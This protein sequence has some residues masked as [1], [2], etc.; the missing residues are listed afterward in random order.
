MSRASTFALEPLRRRYRRLMARLYRPPLAP[1]LSFL[2]RGNRVECPCCGGTFRKFM[3][4]VKLARANRPNARC[5]NCGARER[6]RLLWLYLRERTSLF[7]D[8][9]RVLH[10]APERILEKRLKSQPNLDYVS[11]DFNVHVRW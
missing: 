9:L 4:T 1:P 5:P 7:S 2:Y 11:A 6:N 8:E 3:P 10:F